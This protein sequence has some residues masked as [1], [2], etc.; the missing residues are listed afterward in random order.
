MPR[1]PRVIRREKSVDHEDD[2]ITDFGF[3]PAENESENNKLELEAPVNE[4]EKIKF[5]VAPNFEEN[6][7]IDGINPR[8]DGKTGGNFGKE[9]I[10]N[11]GEAQS[12]STTI[13]ICDEDGNNPENKSRVEEEVDEETD[14]DNKTPNKWYRYVLYVCLVFALDITLAV[15]LLYK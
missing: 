10:S 12:S 13:K 1:K 3:H 11:P 6:P 15:I 14:G 9:K 4:T 8:P 5:L 2:R 7:L